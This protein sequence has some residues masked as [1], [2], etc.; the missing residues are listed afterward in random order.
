M[1][2]FSM[3]NEPLYGTSSIIGITDIINE[4]TTGVG[5]T[6]DGVLLKDGIVSTDTINEITTGSGVTVEGVLLKDSIVSVDTI[7]E[8]SINTGVTIDGVLLKDSIVSTDT[9]NEQST[10]VGVTIDG[11]LLKDSI[12]STDTI[13]EQSTGVGV[14]VDGVL[15]KDSI[16]STNT[17]SPKSG[18]TTTVS[19][20][21]TIQGD[22]NAVSLGLQSLNI[23]TGGSVLTTDTNNDDISQWLKILD[24]DSGLYRYI[25]CYSSPN[26]QLPVTLAYI[27]CS[28][29]LS[30]DTTIQNQQD[31]QIQWNNASNSTDD[32]IIIVTGGNNDHINIKSAGTYIIMASVSCDTLT[33]LSE[34]YLFFRFR[35]DSTNF[36]TNYQGVFNTDSGQTDYGQV[37][38]SWVGTLTADVTYNFYLSMPEN[39]A[40]TVHAHGGIV[41]IA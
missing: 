21:L 31:A 19:Q 5:V 11:V 4:I 38:I 37:T 30:L 20:N 18:T 6:V 15:L 16:V 3:R 23:N 8:Q 1:T 10:G 35:N 28:S 14:T 27:P 2:D 13:N 33:S 32:D 24:V 39:N 22:T 25:P 29:W 26:L 9:I 41:R 17:I 12:V 7:N 36:L 40:E 34:R